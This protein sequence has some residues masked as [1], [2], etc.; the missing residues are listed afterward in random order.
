[1]H[2]PLAKYA[3]VIEGRSTTELSGIVGQILR[4]ARRAEHLVVF[5]PAD[6][7]AIVNDLQEMIVSPPGIAGKQFEI[8]DH[9][10]S[11]SS[12]STPVVSYRAGRTGER[13]GL[14]P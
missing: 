4:D 6:M 13:H 11:Q 10:S 9:T 14:L 7:A 12:K 1:V 5:R 3:F 2:Q 8:D